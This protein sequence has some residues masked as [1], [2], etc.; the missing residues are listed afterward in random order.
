[1]TEHPTTSRSHAA[2]YLASGG[3]SLVG[4]GFASVV[5][6]LLVLG[7]SGR[8]LDAGVVALASGAAM[9]LVGIPTGPLAD[10]Y[11]RRTM[12]AIS[13]C[14]SGLSMVGL[15]TALALGADQLHWFILFAVLGA[16]GD[17]PGLTAREAMLP[18][19]VR[20]GGME[21]SALVGIRQSI[22][23]LS[24]VI[25][26][27]LAGILTSIVQPP[28]L[29][30]LPGGTSLLAAAL[31]LRLPASIFGTHSDGTPDNY[32][33][34]IRD[35]FRAIYQGSP[36]IGSVVLVTVA[37][38]VLAGVL[39]GI[40]FPLYFLS[41]GRPEGSGFALAGLGLGLLV[42]G[43][44]YAVFAKRATVRRWVL[45]GLVANVASLALLL[46]VTGYHATILGAFIVGACSAPLGGALSVVGL[47]VIPEQLRGR[48]MS[49]QNTLGI[50]VTPIAVFLTSLAATVTDPRLAAG[51]LF[52][53]WSLVAGIALLRPKVIAAMEEPTESS[54]SG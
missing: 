8:P 29:L 31:T 44:G 11:N 5:L 12:S 32:V 25:G 37:S 22:A 23:A 28:Y 7:I 27:S 40:L 1:M 33:G 50:A 14:L 35:G 13:D 16:V 34:Q 3:L 17:M 9:V 4:N 21:A 49:I 24:V 43:A 48:V 41:I 10:R 19:I 47:N 36:A 52:A 30:L 51:L 6:P 39:Q 46:G 2:L 53:V 45:G 38:V 15:A 26:P 18:G 54:P 20:S 42:G